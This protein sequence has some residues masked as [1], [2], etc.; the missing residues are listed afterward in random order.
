MTYLLDTNAVTALLQAKSPLFGRVRHHPS[1]RF[2]LSSLV[3]HQLYYGAYYGQRTNETLDRFEGLR[4]EI[5][6]F[7]ADDARCAAEIRTRL[8]R[9]GTPIEPYDVLIAGQA[10]AR[11]LTLITRN[12]GEFSRIKELRS[13]NWEA[14]A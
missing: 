6:P 7:D 11:G 14:S 8:R 4:F 3:M 12:I 13:E 1:S 2:K 10:V 5:L 9:L